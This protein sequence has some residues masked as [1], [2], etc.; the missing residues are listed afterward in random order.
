MYCFLYQ[1]KKIF[2][3]LFTTK[4]PHA[5]EATAVEACFGCFSG[6]VALFNSLCKRK[7][8][9]TSVKLQKLYMDKQKKA[10][11]EQITQ[12]VP[13]KKLSWLYTFAITYMH[14]NS[15]GN[16]QRNHGMAFDR[17]SR[18]IKAFIYLQ[19]G[20]QALKFTFEFAGVIF[21]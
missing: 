2:S 21:S 10:A 3:K 7:K 14:S 11:I 6:M 8:E 9:N 19:A 13:K 1:E 5:K 18:Q 16:L 20:Q 17:V 15:C 12:L 4:A